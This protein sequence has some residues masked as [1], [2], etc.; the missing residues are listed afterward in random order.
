[1]NLVSP[2][3]LK[4]FRVILRSR[5]AY[6]LLLGLLIVVGGTFWLFWLT[7]T[8][9]ASLGARTQ[10]SRTMFLLLT[11]VQLTAFGIISPV[12][13]ATAVTSERENKTLDLLCCTGLSRIHLLLGKWFSAIAYQLLLIAC[14]MPVLA[15][16][17]QLGGVGLDEYLTAAV[18][19]T[20]TVL[21]YGMTGLAFS[22]L[23][24]KTTTALIASLVTV[25][26]LG[27]LA[28]LLILLLSRQLTLGPM[29]AGYFG[30]RGNSSSVLLDFIGSMSPIT[31][32][33]SYDVLPSTSAGTA[34]GGSAGGFLTIFITHPMFRTHLVIQTVIFIVSACVAWIAFARRDVGRLVSAQ[35]IIDDPG[36]L[37][38]RRLHW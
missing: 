2:V 36:I 25:L 38:R 33:F 3:L 9:N 14:L 12:M 37:R 20:L 7:E 35:Q 17:F 27:G 8:R 16:V 24:R 31:T 5:V 11:V 6:W 18:M 30:S 22:C 13:T 26:I 29:V 23:S 32:W 4:E 21:T 15:L 34:A 10:F 28:P 19:I 1:M